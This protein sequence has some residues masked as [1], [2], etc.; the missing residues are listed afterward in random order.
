MLCMLWTLRH[1]CRAPLILADVQPAPHAGGRWG[2]LTG[3]A[4]KVYSLYTDGTGCSWAA[5]GSAGEPGGKATFI[6]AL[7]FTGG[8]VRVTTALPSKAPRGCYKVR[9]RQGCRVRARC[10][11][12]LAAHQASI[13]YGNILSHPS[14]GLHGLL[15]ALPA[16]FLSSRV[17]LGGEGQC[18]APGLPPVC[19]DG[20]GSHLCRCSRC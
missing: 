7:T 1:T 17:A 2:L 10:G 9:L 13:P 19:P 16:A 8:L 14:A 18:P 20:P 11:A 3:Q 5:P 4:G 6:R 15:V 12:G